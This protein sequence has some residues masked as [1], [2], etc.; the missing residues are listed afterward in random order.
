MRKWIV[1]MMRK[2]WHCCLKTVCIFVARTRFI[3]DFRNGIIYMPN[4]QEMVAELFQAKC[5]AIKYQSSYMYTTRKRECPTNLLIT[6][7]VIQNSGIPREKGPPC[8]LVVPEGHHVGSIGEAL[9]LDG[10]QFWEYMLLVWHLLQKIQ[11]KGSR[12]RPLLL[13]FGRYPFS[14]SWQSVF[15]THS[16]SFW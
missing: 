7:T 13:Q 10:R 11:Q 5:L 3:C 16:Q 6:F 2:K 15:T 8:S 9:Q 1:N 4:M 12:H 14:V